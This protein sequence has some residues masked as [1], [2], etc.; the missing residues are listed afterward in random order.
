MSVA[1]IT[2]VP[3]AERLKLS[4]LSAH[5]A[6]LLD[7]PSGEPLSTYVCCGGGERLGDVMA[8]VTLLQ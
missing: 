2:P 7:A 4:A 5:S 6:T 8:D 1:E 3:E